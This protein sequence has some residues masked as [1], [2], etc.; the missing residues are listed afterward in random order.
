MKELAARFNEI[1]STEKLLQLKY[2]KTHIF[3]SFAERVLVP[4]EFM[5]AGQ[6][7]KCLILFLVMQKVGIIRSDF[8]IKHNLHNVSRLPASVIDVFRFIYRWDCNLIYLQLW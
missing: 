4:A 8:C 7:A 1:F 5:N 3:W 6:N 2:G